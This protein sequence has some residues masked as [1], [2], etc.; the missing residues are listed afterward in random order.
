MT[1]AIL[2]NQVSD[3]RPKIDMEKE[4][5]KAFAEQLCTHLA[6]TYRLLINTQG[7]HWNTQGPLFYSI[8]KLTETQYEELF[9]SIDV[10]AERIRAL[11]YPA[12]QSLTQ[13]A[14][15]SSVGDLVVNGEL[16]SQIIRLIEINEKTASQMRD[17]IENA[18]QCRDYVTAGLLTERINAHEE[19]AWMLRATIAS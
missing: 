19:N 15:A 10:I 6:N 17:T 18:E 14:D 1:Q 5:R 13:L 16:E 9:A 4:E 8:H 2:K 11:G 7:V 3:L 12:Q